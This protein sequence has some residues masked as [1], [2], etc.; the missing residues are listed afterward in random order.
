MNN[1]D[2]QFFI[3]VEG[4]TYQTLNDNFI[5]SYLMK[6]SFEEAENEKE[7]EFDSLEY[8]DWDISKVAKFETYQEALGVATQLRIEGHSEILFSPIVN[9]KFTDKKKSLKTKVV[10]DFTTIFILCLVFGIFFQNS[11]SWE[12]IGLGIIFVIGFQ[13]LMAKKDIKTITKI[14]DLKIEAFK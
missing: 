11:Y 13:F 2:D 1:E 9:G 3:I 7:W 4:E 14:A 6:R 10:G 8:F 5:D 12:T